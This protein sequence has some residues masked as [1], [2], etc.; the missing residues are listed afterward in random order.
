MTSHGLAHMAVYMA[1]YMAREGSQTIEVQ[2]IPHP[3]N[4]PLV[5]FVALLTPSPQNTL[6]VGTHDHNNLPLNT[7]GYGHKSLNTYEGSTREIV[8]HR[9]S[10]YSNLAGGS[11]S[12]LE[13]SQDTMLI[14]PFPRSLYLSLWFEA[15][16]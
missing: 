13:F 9:T 3:N 4:P 15:L 11:L 12:S 10:V 1:I 5:G 8:L 16:T 6:G 14:L 2:Q 7:L